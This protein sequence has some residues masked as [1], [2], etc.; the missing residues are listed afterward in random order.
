MKL[1]P[2]SVC[3]CIEGCIYT[4]WKFQDF[5]A[6]IFFKNSVKL[7]VLLKNFTVCELILQKWKN[8]KFTLTEKI[9]RQINYVFSN[10]FST[11]WKS[12]IKRDQAQ[13]IPVKSTL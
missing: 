1:K 9:F 8:K 12:T 11:V 2:V 4:A 6:T 3:L 13:K 5:H 10:F 7:T